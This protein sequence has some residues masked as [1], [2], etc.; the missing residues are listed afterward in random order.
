MNPRQVSA[1]LFGMKATEEKLSSKAQRVLSKSAE[2]SVELGMAL[3]QGLRPGDVVAFFGEIGSG[4]TTV[5]RGVCRGL[6]SEDIVSSPTFTL[7]NEYSARVPIYHFDF[8][9]IETRDEIWQL[10]CEE[11]FYGDGICLIEWAEIVE[12]ILPP[13][14][15]EIHLN[16]LYAEGKEN[17]REMRIFRP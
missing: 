6:G 13:E 14:R 9:R 10:G 11:Y 2:A 17:T 15:I 3:G 5:I 7:I 16:S 4:K 8:Y 12:D 1:T